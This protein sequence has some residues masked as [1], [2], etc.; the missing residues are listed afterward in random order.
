MTLSVYVL[1]CENNKYYVGQSYNV[2][3]RYQQHLEGK[4]EGSEW[5]RIYKPKRILSI[6]PNVDTF[7]EDMKVKQVMSSYGI[8][9]VRGGSYVRFTL[10][11]E[12]REFLRIE[13]LNA[14]NL[15]VRCHKPSAVNF[16]LQLVT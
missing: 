3:R 8:D 5:T 15:C 6:H 16:S 11:S 7:H 12:Q 2:Q 13:I 4:G 14:A 10:S 9:N 1:E